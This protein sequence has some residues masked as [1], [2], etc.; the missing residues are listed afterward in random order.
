MQFQD[1]L[2]LPGE[3]VVD[4]PSD[5]ED[6]KDTGTQMFDIPDEVPGTSGGVDASIGEEDLDEKDLEADMKM[7]INQKNT[8]VSAYRSLRHCSPRP[9]VSSVC[10]VH[11]HSW[12]GDG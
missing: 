8:F 1:A 5:D 3:A 2:S 10:S 11:R 4:I 12:S 6:S 7:K 9:G